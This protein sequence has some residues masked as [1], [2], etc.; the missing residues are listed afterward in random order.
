MSHRELNSLLAGRERVPARG[1]EGWTLRLLSA[2]EV[3]QARREAAELAGDALEQAVCSNACLL[4][5][6]LERRNRPVF[7]SG[8]QVLEGLR[9]EEIGRLASQW[10]AFNRAENP[11]PEDG[12]ERVNGLKKAWSTRLMSALNGVCSAALAFCPDRKRRSG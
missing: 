11:S 12:E 5:K 4:A 9:V 2:A 3:L 6:A 8:A 1:R 10:S 7:A